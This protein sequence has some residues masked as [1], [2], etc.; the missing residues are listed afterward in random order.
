MELPVVN[1]VG[2][3][4]N[5]YITCTEIL[6]RNICISM[7]IFLRAYIYFY[8]CVDLY[9][10][11]EIIIVIVARITGHQRDTLFDVEKNWVALVELYWPVTRKKILQQVCSVST[12]V[13][14]LY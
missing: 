14:L 12:V 3:H 13:M 9:L 7:R 10:I 6:T 5:I 2:I 1:Y 8:I 11:R 4:I